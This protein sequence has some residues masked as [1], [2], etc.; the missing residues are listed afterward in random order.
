MWKN[1]LTVA[2]VWAKDKAKKE[3]AES[4]GYDVLT[5]WESD[6]NRDKEKCLKQTKEFL[7]GTQNEN[8]Q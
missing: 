4:Y 5:I 1:G 3:L 2:A 8:C 6:W 7:K